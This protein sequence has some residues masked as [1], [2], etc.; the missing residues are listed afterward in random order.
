[1]NKNW[2]YF[3]GWTKIWNKH[4]ALYSEYR[5]PAE[6]ARRMCPQD[7]WIPALRGLEEC[8]AGPAECESN[9]QA[10]QVG[11]EGDAQDSLTGPG[12]FGRQ[13][14]ESDCEQDRRAAEGDDQAGWSSRQGDRFNKCAVLYVWNE[15]PDGYA[16]DRFC[17]VD[18]VSVWAEAEW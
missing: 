5:V 17:V 4:Q 15:E 10:S 2:L 8:K 9:H 14:L 1:M 7:K 6:Q 16:R 13:V 11:H 12:E 18:A 3:D